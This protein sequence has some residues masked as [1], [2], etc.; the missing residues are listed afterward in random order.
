MRLPEELRREAKDYVLARVT[1]AREVDLGLYR[2]DWD[3]TFFALLMNGDGT[4]YHR[5][6]TRDW[7]SPL[8]WVSM[9][10]LVALLRATKTDHADY[11]AEKA[12]GRAKP[13]AWTP[14]RMADLPA[15]V[16]HEK[17]RTLG[18]VHCHNVREFL[19][20]DGLENDR[21]DDDRD[22]WTW[23]TPDRI[24]LELDPVD[25]ALVA[26][27]AEGSPAHAA[28]VRPGDRLG[29][30]GATAVRTVA[31][32]Q[33]ALHEAPWDAT[34]LPLTV[35]RGDETVTATVKLPEGWKRGDALSLSWRPIKWPLR[36]APGFGGP[37]LRAD[38]LARL[39]LPAG[40]FAFR[41]NYFVETGPDAHLGKNAR[42]AGI[43]E[44]D[45]VVAVGGKSDFASVDHFHAWFRLHRKAGSVVTLRVLRD[46]K[47][48]Q[49]A[50][51]VID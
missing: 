9:P 30:A 1:D 13:P 48:R 45:V 35:H 29:R 3:C 31:D 40:S 38:D 36:P 39:G 6:G 33:W 25:Q 8:R 26:E 41:V 5:F 24:G 50:L 34:E 12:A 37:Q 46:G 16:R 27:V 49:L 47:E 20:L 19:R 32:L 4:I 44:G 17:K 7:R 21:W 43:E 22:I 18:C 28:G 15:F 42:K 11:E 23:P 51:P 2:I 10:T 14:R